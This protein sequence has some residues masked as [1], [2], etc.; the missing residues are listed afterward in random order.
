L[1]AAATAQR[2]NFAEEFPEPGDDPE[3]FDII[4]EALQPF[5]S[6]LIPQDVMRT[7]SRR[8]KTHLSQENKRK[9]LIGEGFEDVLAGIIGRLE[10]L[11]SYTSFTRALLHDLPGFYPPRGSDKVKKVDL[12]LVR[13]EEGPRTL[14]TAKWSIRA[15][16]EEQLATDFGEYERLEKAGEDFRYVL[17]TNEFDP[18]RLVAACTRRSGNKPLFTSV[19]HV[20]PQGLLEAYDDDPVRSAAEVRSLISDGR[21]ESLAHWL[22][23]LAL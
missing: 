7:L 2:A 1:L 9:N 12:A 4:E 3:L 11:G 16:R 19:V 14:V 10:D 21:L 20:N 17:I 18:A 8:I 22:E 13:G 15:D 5:L 6:S 23:S